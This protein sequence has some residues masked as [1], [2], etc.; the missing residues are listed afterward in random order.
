MLYCPL[1][2]YS[3][4]TPEKYTA[5]GVPCENAVTLLQR[6]TQ[7]VCIAVFPV[8]FNDLTLI[9]WFFFKLL[10]EFRGSR[11]MSAFNLLELQWDYYEGL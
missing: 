7:P 4:M 1:L 3:H 11:F 6:N 5:S 9:R 10:P 8:A 2:E